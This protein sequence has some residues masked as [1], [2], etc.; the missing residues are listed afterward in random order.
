MFHIQNLY[1][2]FIASLLLN[3]TPGNDM[4]YVASR[5]ISQGIKAGIISALGVFI[6]CFVHITAAV[7]GLSIIIMKS[8]FLFQMIKFIGAG[9]L[10]YLGIKALIS[11]SNLNPEMERLPAVSKWKLLKQGIITNV[12]NPKVALFFLSFLPQFIHIGTPLYKLQLFSLGLWFNLQGTFVLIIVATLIGRSRNFIKSNQR[13]I[14]IQ[15]K[16]TGLILIALGLKVAL[17]SQK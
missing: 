12:L 14:K 3:L 5:S 1:L 15:E 9:Y 16:I 2:F 4:I 8:V 13:F 10:I 7:F 11:K 17:G 6:G